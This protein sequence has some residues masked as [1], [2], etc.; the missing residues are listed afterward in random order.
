MGCVVIGFLATLLLWPTMGYGTGIRNSSTIAVVRIESARVGPWNDGPKQTRVRRAEIDLIVERMLKGRVASRSIHLTVEQSEPG[1][2]TVV[3]PGPW[4]GKSI[5]AGARY[6]LF[7]RSDLSH[8]DRVE[9]PEA[10]ATVKRL[11][12]AERSRLSL[13]KMLSKANNSELNEM[14]GEY[15]L[16]RLEE[17]RFSDFRQFEGILSFL[18]S[19]G[20][21]DHFRQQVLSGMFN[22]AMNA[23][24]VP[25]PF[26]SRLVVS[27][28]RVAASEPGNGF[29][30]TLLSTFLPNLL[31][32]TG[33]LSRKTAD[34][35][36]R[37]YPEDRARAGASSRGSALLTNWLNGR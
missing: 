36:F 18:E 11:I 28:F 12:T 14:M 35:V 30:E 2:R 24:P 23:D 13:D 26:S 17:D 19:Q 27:G 5:D 25:E 10:E 22:L 34:Q 7:S 8:A 20:P 33:G 16:L 4:S 3:V 6:V 21:P 29:Q 37:T 15:V 31:G 9:P 32:L 1:P